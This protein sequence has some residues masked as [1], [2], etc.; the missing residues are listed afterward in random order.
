MIRSLLHSCYS[1]IEADEVLS[2]SIQ[3]KLGSSNS[4]SR[5]NGVSLDAW[6]LYE[7]WILISNS[8]MEYAAGPTVDRIACQAKRMLDTDSIRA[9]AYT[10]RTCIVARHTLL[11]AESELVF[12]PCRLRNHLQP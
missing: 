7:A 3:S 1:C 12:L 5:A 10:L 2:I 6:S 4:F 11:P 8:L 9:S